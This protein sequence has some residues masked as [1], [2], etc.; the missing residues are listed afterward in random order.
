MPRRKNERVKQKAPSNSPGATALPHS[1]SKTAPPN[2]AGETASPDTP[3]ITLA[4]LGLV[5]LAGVPYLNALRDGF[6]YDDRLQVLENPYVHSLR[7]LGRIFGG[8]LWTFQGAQGVTN[9]YRP[10]QVL[11]Y[12][13]L[14]QICGP[15]PLYFHLL[16]LLLHVGVVLLLFA[17]AM[18]LFGDATLAFFSAALFALHPIHTESVVWIADL[19]D[20]E[21]CFFFLLTFLFYVRIGGRERADDS[22]RWVRQGAMLAS[23]VCALLSKEPAMV[24]PLLAAAYEHFYRPGR[25]RVPLRA[26]VARYAPFCVLVFAYVGFR[27]F[28]LGAFAPQ[29]SRADLAW[30]Q[31][32]LSAVALVGGYL[33]KLI[34]PAHLSAFYVFHAAQHIY[35]PAV[36][37]GV[38]G[39][40][41]CFFLFVWLWRHAHMVSFAFL[42]MGATLAP[43]LNARWMTGGV[44]AERYLYLPSVGFC[45][46]AGW[47][48]AMVWHRTQAENASF[49]Y[50]PK[51]IAA[52]AAAGTLFFVCGAAVLRRN[53]NWRTDEI[54]Y[55]RTLEEQPDAQLIRTNLGL[56]YWDNGDAL[57]AEREWVRAMGPEAPYVSTLDNLGLLRT[58]Q[59]RY[60]EAISLFKRAIQDNPAYA[61][62][63]KNL[64]AVYADT[65]RLGDADREFRAAVALA[66]LNT[67]ARN[68]YGHFIAD[69]GRAAEAEEQFRASVNAD[70]ND[71]AEGSLRRLSGNSH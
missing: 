4:L 34:W 6:V 41:V 17:V 52:G 60:P 10:V 28:A 46:I 43:V 32:L 12:L 22:R 37:G 27:R 39:L 66:P 21:L 58:L 3:G 36:V 13:I 14:Y 64:A 55:R 18:A 25:E 68:A 56:V 15:S 61:P 42:W 20:L 16:N 62:A 38:A 9:Y 7:Y 47:L 69:Q 8:T 57:G 71:E 33:E 31:V 63:H 40:L 24:F 5:L 26:K 45:W 35:D 11:S 50:A 51:R 19:T 29:V 65:G 54:L 70:E 2:P 67:E 1:P 49:K 23:Y 30:S 48:M 59:E 53:G 44:F